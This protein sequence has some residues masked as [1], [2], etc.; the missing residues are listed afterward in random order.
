MPARRLNV[1]TRPDCELCEALLAA[2]APY[3][4]AGRIAVSVADLEDQALSLRERHQW[5]IPVVFEGD[6][7]LMWGRIDADE[8]AR[9]LGPLPPA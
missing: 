9:V 7:E 8:I 4:A 2:L 5:R 6:M 3:A 1:L